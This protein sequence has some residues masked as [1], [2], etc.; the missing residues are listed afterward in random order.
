MAPHHT[1]HLLL[2]AA[3]AAAAPAA[4]PPPAAAWRGQ[5]VVRGPQPRFVGHATVPSSEPPVPNHLWP[6]PPI[7]TLPPGTPVALVATS[8]TT[9]A[10]GLCVVDGRAVLPAVVEPPTFGS[11]PSP[12]PSTLR[13]DLDFLS[14]GGLHSVAAY[15]MADDGAVSR[16]GEAL[17]L[18]RVPPP[19]SAA[20]AAAQLRVS[21]TTLAAHTPA[22][23]ASLGVYYTTYLNPL[24]Q[25][26]QNITRMFNRTI[27]MEG[28]LSDPALRF[29]DSVWG[30][31]PAAAGPWWRT[32]SAACDIMHQQPA[33]GMYCFYRKRANETVGPIPDCPEAAD[34]LAAHAAEMSAAG[35]TWVAPDATNWDGDP[36][37]QAPEAPSSDFYQLRPTEVLAEEWAGLRL[38]GTATPSLSIFAKVGLNSSLWRWYMTELFDNETLLALDMVYRAGPDGAGAGKKVFIAA[39]LGPNGTDYNLLQTI[40][41]N[42]GADDVVVPLMWFAP[43]ASGAWEASGRLGYFSRCIA[44]HSDSGELDFS[45]DAWLDPAVPCGHLKTR[46]SPIGSSWTVSTGLSINSVPFGA[47]RFNGL[48]LKKQWWDVLADGEP[49]DVIFAPSWNE[50]GSGAYNLSSVVHADNPAFYAIGAAD[51]DPHRYVLFEDGYGAQRSRT[52]EPSVEDGGRYYETFAS[53]VRVYRLQAAL[54]I[55]SNGTGCE[56]AGEECCATR[57]D[58]EFSH[59]WSLD[60]APAPSSAVVDSMLTADAGELAELLASGWQQVCVPTIFG[61]GPTA[62]CVDPNLPF[63]GQAGVDAASRGPFVLYGN[64]TGAALPGTVP[65]VRCIDPATGRHLAT[66]A[67]DGT[68]CARAAAGFQFDTL[69]GYGMAAPDSLFVRAVRR[70]LASSAPQPSRHY[71]AVG[72]PCLGGDT[73]EGVLLF[74]A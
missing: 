16:I 60:S 45:T 15:G 17:L 3:F 64:S 22:G 29:A 38:A 56:V 8:N 11:S 37:G 12:S 54:G 48:L 33:L 1:A 43:N 50:F 53:C 32:Y 63:A 66:N 39:D 46:A 72:T 67:T 58:E 44:R 14:Y 73:D 68:A 24:A 62:T 30:P 74:A 20:T 4:A 36:R 6:G 9:P 35:F 13:C 57:E 55:V 19:A 27:T 41:D 69:L 51:D 59:V 10:R 31:G 47:A 28:V 40:A 34:V 5:R 61:R 26:Y 2:L 52:I 65:M 18:T 70:C 23:T 7:H 21:E 71:T 42:A 25:L 49:T